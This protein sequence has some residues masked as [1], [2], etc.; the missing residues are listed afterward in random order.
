MQKKEFFIPS[1]NGKNK[2]HT[3]MW[4]PDE[5]CEVQGIIQI[6]HGMVEYVDR[7]DRFAK[8]LVSLG[9]VVIGNDHLGH[10][11]TAANDA[12]LGYMAAG[13]ASEAMVRDL[14]KI[15]RYVRGRYPDV[16]FY[17][18]GH[19]MGS[20][21]ARRYAMTYPKEMKGLIL[22]GTGYQPKAVLVMAYALLAFLRKR[23]GERFRSK[24]LV[25]AVFGTYNLRFS[26]KNTHN[27]WVTRDEKIL[28]AYDKDKYCTFL[29]T[30]KGFKTLFDTIWF[31]QKKAN[32]KKLNAK[33][34]MLFLSGDMDPVGFYSKGVK[35]V[36]DDYQKAGIEDIEAIFYKGARH[37]VLNELEYEKTHQD[38]A[39]WLQKKSMD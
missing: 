1:C 38:I 8:F 30:I 10:G 19:S 5:S 29:F 13:D 3:I 34:P 25:A 20:V 39:V 35:K 33:V 37:E 12:E 6:S 24:L 31:I 4:L 28:E 14:H 36:I 26:N 16:P 22:L 15:T 17:L 18:L 23:K 2:L 7:Y 27:A 32:I 21:L 9:Y 11:L